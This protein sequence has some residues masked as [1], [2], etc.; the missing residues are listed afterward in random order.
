MGETE[1]IKIGIEFYSRLK[2]KIVNN[3]QV[4]KKYK[5]IVKTRYKMHEWNLL[6]GTL[7][8]GLS[9]SFLRKKFFVFF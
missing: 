2:G 6:G 1:A 9:V 4:T 5:V 3:Q 7:L 8:S